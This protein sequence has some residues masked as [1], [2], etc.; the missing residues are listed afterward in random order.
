MVIKLFETARNPGDRPQL[1]RLVEGRAW[2]GNWIH[3]IFVDDDEI[4][5]SL[6]EGQL[7]RLRALI[8]EPVAALPA[9]AK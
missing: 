7:D 5:N 6:D 3:G 8:N 9:G 2:T 1:Y 4:Y